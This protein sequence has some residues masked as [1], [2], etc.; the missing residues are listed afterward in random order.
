MNVKVMGIVTSCFLGVVVSS[1]TNAALPDIEKDQIVEAVKFTDTLL[2]NVSTKY[3]VA[4]QFNKSIRGGERPEK[5]QLEI[6]WRREG[7]RD[8]YDVTVYDGR[9]IRGKPFRVVT[10][11]NGEHRKQWMPNEDKGDV[12]KEPYK[13]S[14]PIPIDFGLALGK[15]DKTLGESLEECEI[16]TIRKTN[17]ENNECYYVKAIQPNG[18]KAEVW[19]DPTIGWRARNVRLYRPDGLIMYE[20]TA[21]FNDLG[22][23]IYFPVEGTAKLYGNDPNTGERVVSCT[24]KLKLEEVKVNTDLTQEDFDIEFPNSTNVYD[25]I[26]GIGYIVG[27]TSVQG[28]EDATLNEIADEI[29]K[30]VEAEKGSGVDISKGLDQDAETKDGTQTAKTNDEP[31]I[32]N[33]DN[34]AESVMGKTGFHLWWLIALVTAGVL[35]IV[36]I[37]VRKRTA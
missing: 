16:D 30:L 14:W 21:D 29:G 9:L 7:I 25:H 11:Y 23:S 18:A 24:R 27:V 32:N 2:T 5:R 6:Q 15:H 13:S 12:F 28:V 26:H 37:V 19:I 17:W 10:A 20:A 22:N 34:A 33:N 35:C 4:E 1:T 3:V 8:Y 36:Y 31:A